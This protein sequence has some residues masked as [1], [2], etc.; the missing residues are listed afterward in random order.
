[1][2]SRRKED[3]PWR[4]STWTSLTLAQREESPNR[5]FRKP[6]CPGTSRISGKKTPGNGE[7]T[8]FHSGQ[9]WEAA[10][11]QEEAERPAHG[12]H[13]RVAVVHEYL[14]PVLA[15]AKGLQED[16]GLVSV[17]IWDGLLLDFH[18]VHN[19]LWVVGSKSSFPSSFCKE[20]VLLL[21]CCTNTVVQIKQEQ[22]LFKDLRRIREAEKNKAK[23]FPSSTFL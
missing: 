15:L 16:R 18:L 6:S 2:N 11:Y 12:R 20:T 4:P 21:I 7:K 9:Q 22:T 1:M 14:L 5:T 13:D 10:I 17:S 23:R 3:L 8:N 19:L